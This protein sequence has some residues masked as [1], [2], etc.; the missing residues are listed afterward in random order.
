MNSLDKLLKDEIDSL[1]ERIAATVAEGSLAD[2]TASHPA[3]RARLEEA[4]ARLAA[5]RASL[6]EAYGAWGRALEDVE[7]LW[8]LAA[9]KRANPGAIAA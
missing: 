5:L 8:A 1:L 3:L 6:L 7:N 2:V 4:E 9:C